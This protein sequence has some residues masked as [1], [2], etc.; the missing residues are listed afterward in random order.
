M[1]FVEPL[2]TKLMSS[3]SSHVVPCGHDEVRPRRPPLLSDW[4]PLSHLD[5]R[6]ESNGKFEPSSGCE[7]IYWDS[8]PV[9]FF[10]HR[11]GV[12][13]INTYIMS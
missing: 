1:L 4:P 2:H 5:S 13:V 10:S 8:L 7:T 11:D 3:P 9:F 12:Y 6:F